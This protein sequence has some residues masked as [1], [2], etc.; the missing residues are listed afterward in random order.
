MSSQF[1]SVDKSIDVRGKICPYPLIETREALKTM[2]NKQVLEVITD[3][4]SAAK[5]TIPNMCRLKNYLFEV[6]KENDFFRVL[7][8]KSEE[9]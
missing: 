6:V 9:G 1:S 8:Q 7:I 3:H 5:E 4:E 2:E